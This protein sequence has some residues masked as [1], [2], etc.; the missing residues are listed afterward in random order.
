[1]NRKGFTLVELMVVVAI[2]GILAAVALPSYSRMRCKADWSE[3]QGTLA[4]IALR[5]ENYRTNHGAYPTN[6]HWAA[7]GYTGQPYVGRHYEAYVNTTGRTYIIAM[8][9]TAQ[10]INCSGGAGFE[11]DIWVKVNTSP[12][13]IHVVNTVDKTTRPVP[14]GFTLP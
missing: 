9:D 7:L 6:D 1:M 11:N 8:K 13:V 2:V 12:E 5:M 10:P 3:L 14:S 4:D